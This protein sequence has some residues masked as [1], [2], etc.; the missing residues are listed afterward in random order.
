MKLANKDFEEQCFTKGRNLLGSE[1][2]L[3][4][5]NIEADENTENIEKQCPLIHSFA[6]FTT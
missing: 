3:T 4:M 6:L 2:D 1:N 5:V